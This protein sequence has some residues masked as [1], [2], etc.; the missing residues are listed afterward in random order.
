[1]AYMDNQEIVQRNAEVAETWENLKSVNEERLAQLQNRQTVDPLVMEQLQRLNSALDTQ[2]GNVQSTNLTL[3]DLQAKLANLER[4]QYSASLAGAVEVKSLR[5]QDDINDGE[6]EERKAA[7]LEY[8][9]KG[10]DTM[11]LKLDA[12]AMSSATERDGGFVVGAQ[13]QRMIDDILTEKSVMRQLANVQEISTASL[14][15]VDD[16]GSFI[17]NWTT[18]TAA[19]NDTDAP[20]FVRKNIVAHE[21]VAQPK[22]TQKLLDD[23]FINLE[24]WLTDKLA[25]AFLAAED[26]AFINGDGVNKPTGILNYRDEITTLASASGVSAGVNS[27]DIFDL[28]YSLPEEY[29]R[30]AALLTN[31]E[32]LQKLRLLKD[33][34]GQYLWQPNL[35]EGRVDT[36]LGIPVYQSSYIPA[37]TAGSKSII[38]GDFHYYQI[39]DRTGLSILRDPFTAKPYIRFYTTKRVGGDVLRTAAFRVLTLGA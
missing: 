10:D 36:I 14:D 24:G 23:A 18:E 11:L 5:G 32:V 29:A 33:S 6:P 25:T 17:T 20:T 34:N 30:N 21:L 9:R 4:K 37:A 26:D 31:R 2:M 27:D 12:Q 13:I 3:K 39:V 8:L 19:V 22:A 16:A 7:L 38:V 15:V 1:M 28:V 35:S